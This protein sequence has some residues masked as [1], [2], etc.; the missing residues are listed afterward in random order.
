MFPFALT[1]LGFLVIG[2]G[3]AWQRNEAVLSA[4]LRKLLPGPLR[5]LVEHVD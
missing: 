3:I 2:L 5:E 1:F 4:A